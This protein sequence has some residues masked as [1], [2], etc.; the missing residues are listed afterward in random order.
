MSNFTA[1]SPNC[2]GVCWCPHCLLSTFV[3]VNFTK[4]QEVWPKTVLSEEEYA[5]VA[6]LRSCPMRDAFGF[7]YFG[8]NCYLS[9]GGGIPASATAQVIALEQNCATGTLNASEVLGTLMNLG[10]LEMQLDDEDRAPPCRVCGSMDMPSNFF[11]KVGETA[12]VRSCPSCGLAVYFPEMYYLT[13]CIQEGCGDNHQQYKAKIDE[14]RQHLPF[15]FK[16]PMSYEGHRLATLVYAWS[17]VGPAE[18]SRALGACFAVNPLIDTVISVGSGS[19]YAEHVFLEASKHLRPEMVTRLF[20]FD[21]RVPAKQRFSVVVSEGT[22][23]V[24]TSFQHQIHQCAMLLCW[25]PF[26]SREGEQSTMAFD[27]LRC[28]GDSGGKVVIYIG[29]VASTGDW[30]FHEL[31]A[32]EWKPAKGYRVRHEIERWDP[33]AMGLVFA[34]NDTIGVYVKRV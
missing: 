14:A 22:P 1:H 18:A 20:A 30:R 11:T 9:H 7:C 17:L 10:E 33:Y 34:G 4:G 2:D 32:R 26:G 28:F 19:G 12:F 25:P 13:R 15:P 21:E 6:N 23:S 16:V 31:L 8:D 29:D 5:Y 3:T 27:A 24:I